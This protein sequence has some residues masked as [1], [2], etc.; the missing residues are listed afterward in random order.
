[1]WPPLASALAEHR[2]G[3]AGGREG[4]RR[5]SALA[6]HTVP[7]MVRAKDSG[8]GAADLVATHIE[9]YRRVERPPSARFG[10][11]ALTALGNN[12]LRPQVGHAPEFTDQ[13]C[14][15]TGTGLNNL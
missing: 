8:L 7:L 2:N 4:T 6:E 11:L 12:D 15:R 1:M 13:L 14:P 10:F 5:P 9:A 3:V